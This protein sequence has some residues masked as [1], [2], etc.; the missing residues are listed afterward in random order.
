MVWLLKFSL[1]CLTFSVFL[2]VPLYLSFFFSINFLLLFSY[3]FFFLSRKHSYFLSVLSIAS[4]EE[5]NPNSVL[6][7]YLSF[8]I[9]SYSLSFFSLYL[10]FFFLSLSLFPL[11]SLSAAFLL[12][13]LF[14]LLDICIFLLIIF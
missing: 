10:S 12:C 13:E 8:F 11:L 4:C 3:T 2:H 6:S 7:L 1:Y 5:L 9:F 14:C